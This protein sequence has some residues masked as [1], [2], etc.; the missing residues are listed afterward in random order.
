MF[1]NQT[2]C[3]K[4]QETDQIKKEEYFNNDINSK[5]QKYLSF[6]ARNDIKSL[7]AESS[8]ILCVKTT[9]KLFEKSPNCTD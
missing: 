8:L 1:K 5:Q 7:L 2:N 6:C 9:F 3:W 4:I